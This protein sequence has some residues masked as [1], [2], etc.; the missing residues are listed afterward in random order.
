MRRRLQ[1]RIAIAIA[2]AFAASVALQASIGGQA[3]AESYK[4]APMASASLTITVRASRDA[5]FE[6]KLEMSS[7]EYAKALKQAKTESAD[8]AETLPDVDIELLY[9][10]AKA[11]Y[12]LEEKTGYLWNAEQRLRQKLPAEASGKLLRLAEALRTKHYGAMRPWESVKQTLP[13]KRVFAVADL[14]SGLTFNVQRRA[15]SDHADVQ[16]VTKEDTAVMKQIYSGN[17][18]WKRKAVLVQSDE[19]WIAASMNGMPHGGDGIPDNGFS[20]HFCIHFLGSSTHK[21]EFPD[22]AHQLMVHKAGG[23]LTA[24]FDSSSP[25]ALAKTFIV[26]LHHREEDVLR[27][28]GKEMPAEQVDEFVRKMETLETFKETPRKNAEAADRD[29]DD[30]SNI[31]EELEVK[32]VIPVTVKVKNEPEQKTRI[33][34]EFRRKS[35]E[36]PW[37]LVN[38]T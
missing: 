23:E 35:K 22:L 20:G 16:P 12:Q 32:V 2:A 21:S 26:L 17:W 36:S 4:R 30:V 1:K 37:R 18:S 29:N 11:H 9:D 38:A 27:Q 14:E 3:Y 8:A 15:G 7:R 25:L 6:S 10:G 31:A 28:L 5:A 24:L 19:G 13:N 33:S 34:F